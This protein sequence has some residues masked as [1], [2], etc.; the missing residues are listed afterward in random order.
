MDIGS[1]SRKE[2]R[3]K[4]RYNVSREALAK[5]EGFLTVVADMVAYILAGGD[6]QTIRQHLQRTYNVEN[7]N[8]HRIQGFD[9][10][11]ITC[12]SN[13]VSIPF[14]QITT[15]RDKNNIPLPKL[16]IDDSSLLLRVWPKGHYR[17]G[18]LKKGDLKIEWGNY[19]ISIADYDLCDH[20]FLDLINKVIKVL[21]E[22]RKPQAGEDRERQRGK[23]VELRGLLKDSDK[24]IAI[25]GDL[26][27]NEKNIER[28]LEEDGLEEKLEHN[29]A[30]LVIAGDMLCPA[31]LAFTGHDGV[32]YPA[33]QK[34]L[35]LTEKSAGFEDME[36]SLKVLERVLTLKSRFPAGVYYIIG[37]HDNPYFFKTSKPISQNTVFQNQ[38]LL[39]YGCECRR[40]LIDFLNMSPLLFITDG[41]VVAHGGPIKGSILA[42]LKAKGKDLAQVLK[43]ERLDL[44]DMDYDINKTESNAV[45]QLALGMHRLYNNRPWLKYSSKDVAAFLN[46][47]QMPSQVKK[48]FFVV[49]HDH[50]FNRVEHDNTATGKVY[51]AQAFWAWTFGPSVPGHYIIFS[52]GIKSTG[53]AIIKDGDIRFNTVR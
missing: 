16:D 27:G 34:P 40:R 2:Y 26:H 48:T 7:K 45:S 53:Y 38:I 39:R 43:E 9:F 8:L 21:E 31:E 5:D 3:P 30:I 13:V 6:K 37:N 29:R 46:A 18:Q 36:A 35:S 28:I 47:I 32:P 4:R 11:N 25:I 51:Q 52:G 23:V 1:D 24:E 20:A 10:K 14:A 49:G 33:T 15:F 12:Q 17:N 42:E 50:D 22:N 19:I 41:V 44:Q